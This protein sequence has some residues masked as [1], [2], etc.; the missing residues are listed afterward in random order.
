VIDGNRIH[1]D[2][3]GIFSGGTPGAVTGVGIQVD[4]SRGTIAISGNTIDKVNEA[5]LVHAASQA[6]A[7]DIGG[8]TLSNGAKLIEVDNAQGGLT[9][10]N[11]ILSDADN[12][13]SVLTISNGATMTVNDNSLSDVRIQIHDAADGGVSVVHNSIGTT[14]NFDAIAL[15]GFINGNVN[16]SDNRLSHGRV[17]I[18]GFFGRNLLVRDNVIVGANQSAIENQAQ[19]S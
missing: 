12:N 8:N 3:D 10:H 6:G 4:G 7:V 2:T 16:I 1:I 14:G 18:A 5:V 15:D 11:N 19:I 17:L 9:V 13:S